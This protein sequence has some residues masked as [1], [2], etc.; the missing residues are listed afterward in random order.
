M[1]TAPITRVWRRA[2]RATPR[3]GAPAGVTFAPVLHITMLC[4]SR[5]APPSRAAPRAHDAHVPPVA[6]ALAPSRVAPRPPLA[7]AAPQVMATLARVITH[8]ERADS[9]P[10]AQGA[11]V[12]MLALA[13]ALSSE[14]HAWR[15]ARPIVRVLRARAPAPVLEDADM[16]ARRTS[17]AMR[18]PLPAPALS[19]AEVARLTEHVLRTMDRRVSAFRERQGRS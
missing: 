5:A 14:S 9:A 1:H 11:Y 18:E 2:P 15:A 13:G 6:R 3:R 16:P 7:I 8:G 19:A 17:L 12:R 4:G 10:S